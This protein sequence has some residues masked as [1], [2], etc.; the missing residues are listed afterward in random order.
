MITVGGWAIQG[1]MILC[2]AGL[3]GWACYEIKDNGDITASTVLIPVFIFTVMLLAFIAA[4]S[5]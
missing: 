3:F 1:I 5:I 2:I 4:N